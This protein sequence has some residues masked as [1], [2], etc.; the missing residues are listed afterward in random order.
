M[1]ALAIIC[2]VVAILALVVG[3][4]SR[5]TLRPISTIEAK[6]F[7]QFAQTCLLLAIVFLL[8]GKK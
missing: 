6:A 1:K 3:I 2:V 4:Y 5:L 7:L 8:M